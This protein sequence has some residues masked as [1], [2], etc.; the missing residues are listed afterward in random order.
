M[1]PESIRTIVVSGLKDSLRSLYQQCT[2]SLQAGEIDRAKMLA[3]K[4]LEVRMSL[5][6]YNWDGVL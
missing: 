1:I 3:D 5:Y 6:Y 4:A 2:L